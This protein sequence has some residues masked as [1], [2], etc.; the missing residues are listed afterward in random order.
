MDT[1][2]FVRCA[3]E[4]FLRYIDIE[5][6]SE[7]L[8]LYQISPGHM[9]DIFVDWIKAD[10]TNLDRLVTTYKSLIDHLQGVYD[11]E[12]VIEIILE[13]ALSDILFYKEKS[14]RYRSS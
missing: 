11:R 2:I 10:L 13:T 7:L 6:Q 4:S 8:F 3:R 12:E 1:D 14:A 5:T 9:F